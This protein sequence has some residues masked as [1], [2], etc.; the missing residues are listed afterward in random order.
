MATVTTACPTWCNHHPGMEPEVHSS[1]SWAACGLEL[2]FSQH[3]GH[4][5]SIGVDHGPR[6]NL[7]LTEE[8]AHELGMALV[9]TVDR[10]RGARMETQ[11]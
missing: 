11:A 10:I 2:G 8:Q 4:S 1:S 6:E 5:V 7:T 3:P 9:R